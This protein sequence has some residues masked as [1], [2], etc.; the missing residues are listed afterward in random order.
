LGSTA[1]IAGL[2]KPNAA[3]IKIILQELCILGTKIILNPSLFVLFYRWEVANPAPDPMPI[4]A[5]Q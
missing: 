5:N 4:C 3:A 1:A 2:V